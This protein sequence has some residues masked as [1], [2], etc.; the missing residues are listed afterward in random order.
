MC[1]HAHIPAPLRPAS[2][3]PRTPEKPDSH[4]VLEVSGLRDGR[5]V[6][7]ALLRV[8]LGARINVDTNAGRVRIEGR[9]WKEE[10]VTAIE[11]LGCTLDRVAERPRSRPEAGSQRGWQ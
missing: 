4:L 3:S 10:V 8:D 9:F 1:L 6:V 11:R 2:D 7:D 5:E